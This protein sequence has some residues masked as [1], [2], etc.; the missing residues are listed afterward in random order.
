[1]N[2]E[3]IKWFLEHE[4]DKPDKLA[5]NKTFQVLKTFLKPMG[6]WKNKA[7]GKSDIRHM[8]KT[9]GGESTTHEE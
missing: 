6:Y 9:T 7:R 3:L 4:D 8:T 5:H 1:M 2:N